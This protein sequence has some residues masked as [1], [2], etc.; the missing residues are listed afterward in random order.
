MAGGAGVD[1][2]TVTLDVPALAADDEDDGVLVERV[3]ELAVR[4]RGRVEEPA[5][6]EV[7]R[8]ALDLDADLAAVHEVELVL[9]VVVVREALVARRVD[10]RVDAERLDAERLPDLPEAVAVAEL[11]E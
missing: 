1:G 5:L 10:G 2:V 8:L 6:P 11:V 4:R 7:A 3:R 9:R